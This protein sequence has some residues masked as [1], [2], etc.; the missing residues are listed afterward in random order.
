MLGSFRLTYFPKSGKYADMKLIDWM[1][2]EDLDDEQ[3]AARHGDCT[4]FAVK[5]WKY[6]ERTPRNAQ[7]RRLTEISN[8][9][10]TANDFVKAAPEPV[11]AAS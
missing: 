9:R 5:K 6:G 1:R 7:M 8:G 11:R 2:E 3:V 10:V 4:G